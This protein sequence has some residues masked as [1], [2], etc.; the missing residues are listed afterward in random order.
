STAPISAAVKMFMVY[1]Y[2]IPQ[3]RQRYRCKAQTLQP[4]PY[5]A[6]RKPPSF[7]NQMQEYLSA[8]QGLGH[9]RSAEHAPANPVIS[10]LSLFR[11]T[12]QAVRCGHRLLQEI[13]LIPQRPVELARQLS[14]FRSKRGPPAFE[15]KH[16]DDPPIR[17]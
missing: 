5:Q 1:L 3:C 2:A 14:R 7:F 9:L 13:I 4:A 12:R 16:R 10:N 8:S 17:S 11:S 15:K 6:D